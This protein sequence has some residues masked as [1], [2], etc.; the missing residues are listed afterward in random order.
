MVLRRGRIVAE[1]HKVMPLALRHSRRAASSTLAASVGATVVLALLAPAARA[2]AAIEPPAWRALTITD[3]TH[4][5]PGSPRKEIQAVTVNA[6][7]GTFTLT[8]KGPWCEHDETS[9]PI[10]HG[11]DYTGIRRRIA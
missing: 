1:A 4:L 3:P 5:V 2:L 11:A 10:P 6:N 7:G 8:G 9:A